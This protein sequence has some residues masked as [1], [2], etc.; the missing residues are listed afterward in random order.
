[1]CKEG[2]PCNPFYRALWS[3]LIDQIIH[4]SIRLTDYN[5]PK[6][7]FTVLLMKRR[8]AAIYPIVYDQIKDV[9]KLW[10]I[11]ARSTGIFSL[12]T[13]P[14]N[15]ISVDFRVDFYLDFSGY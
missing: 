5:I 7:A 3:R 1:M 2:T 13:N 12:H 9:E 8:A 15:G 11:K 6:M 14:L 10:S 4:E